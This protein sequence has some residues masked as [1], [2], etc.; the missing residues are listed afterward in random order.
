MNASTL[1]HKISEITLSKVSYTPSSLCY[2]T[3]LTEGWDGCDRKSTQAYIEKL[4]AAAYDKSKR[5][6]HSPIRILTELP[7]DYQPNVDYS[8]DY[9]WFTVYVDGDG[10]DIWVLQNP[11]T[12]CSL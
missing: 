6:F 5:W 8:L 12:E 3:D 7:D 2:L 1:I 4:E 9:F 11:H 10:S